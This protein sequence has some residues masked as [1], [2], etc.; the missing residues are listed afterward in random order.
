[1][2]IVSTGGLLPP[3]V[4]SRIP[5]AVAAH[6][7]IDYKDYRSYYSYACLDTGGYN[8]FSY[9]SY[10][11]GWEGG[12]ITVAQVVNATTGC[13]LLTGGSPAQFNLT[14]QFTVTVSHIS[15]CALFTL[16]TGSQLHLAT[17]QGCP[18]LLQSINQSINV[19]SVDLLTLLLTTM[20]G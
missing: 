8:L 18:Y 2:L 11:N 6:A 4:R 7:Q 19:T 12:R 20:C 13:T 15:C 3:S 1:M 9:D 14:T 17:Q 5:S 16:N 10:G